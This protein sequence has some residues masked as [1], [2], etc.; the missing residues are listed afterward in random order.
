MSYLQFCHYL[1]TTDLATTLHCDTDKE[2]NHIRGCSL[3]KKSNDKS[4]SLLLKPC[5]YWTMQSA[6]HLYTKSFN[7][8]TYNTNTNSYAL[9]GENKT[10]SMLHNGLLDLMNRSTCFGHYY[11][12]HQELATIQMV[13]AYGSSP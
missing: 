4:M 6:Q 10:N 9:H 7:V 8:H 2:G 3:C 13:S 5:I 1:F 11:A 12:H